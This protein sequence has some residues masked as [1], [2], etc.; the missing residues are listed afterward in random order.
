[1]YQHHE[2]IKT[3]ADAARALEPF[4]GPAAKILFAL[5]LI[6]S[7]IMAIPILA[8]S[9]GYMVAEVFGWKQSLSDQIDSA[10]GF[11]IVITVSLFMGVEIA[12]SGFDPI[13][14][15]FYSQ[16]LAGMIGPFVLVLLLIV[17]NN[18]GIMGKLTNTGFDNFFTILAV[19]VLSASTI[20]LLLQSFLGN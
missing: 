8:S 17:A 6:G 10:K 9:A 16:I 14:V 3:A 4:A 12:V 11:Y 1:L 5:G 19:L 7:G 2:Q 18:K 13:Q 20:L 15:M